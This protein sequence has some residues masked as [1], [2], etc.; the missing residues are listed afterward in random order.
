[1]KPNATK[2]L[3]MAGLF[4]IAIMWVAGMGLMAGVVGK[5]RA[6]PRS[7]TAFTDD[8]SIKAEVTHV[9]RD[10]DFAITLS[11][12]VTDKNGNVLTGLPEQNFEVYEDGELVGGLKNFAPAGHG[13][14]RVCLVMDYSN[15]MRGQKIDGAK[16]AALALLDML[17]DHSDHLGLYFFNN[18]LAKSG[19]ELLTMG[20]LDPSRRAQAKQ[21]IENTALNNGTPM[22]EAMERA[23]VKLETMQG[24]KVMVVLTDGLDTQSKGAAADKR[25]S[26]LGQTAQRLGV[27]LYTISLMGGKNDDGGLQKL[28]EAGKGKFFHA[29]TP[30]K[31]KDIFINIGEALQKEYTLTYDSPDPVENGRARKVA[32]AIRSGS[33]GTHADTDYHVPGLVTTG[34]ARRPAAS[35]QGQDAGSAPVG[36]VFLPLGLLLSGLFAGPYYLWL[37]PRTANPAAAPAPAEKPD[38]PAGP[39]AK[40]W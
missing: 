33:V 5:S 34:G 9:D 28:A 38:A 39:E 13:P 7:A 21:I 1:M 10:K 4:A 27:P 8:G 12:K 23:F 22:F 24:R 20:P 11:M 3:V 14:V 17:R 18:T 25:I 37:R 2:L 19:N 29:P 36:T 32:V 15:S 35:G 26:G 6:A 30:D 16:K 40:L 31:L